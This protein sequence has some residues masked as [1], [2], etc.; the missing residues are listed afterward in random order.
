MV[1]ENIVM[2]YQSPYAHTACLPVSLG[3]LELISF[4]WRVQRCLSCGIKVVISSFYIGLAGV[5][6]D[7]SL[8]R[9]WGWVAYGLQGKGIV[10]PI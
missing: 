5:F 8:G 7:P 6:V 3:F 10:W 9:F 4:K 1:G 2:G